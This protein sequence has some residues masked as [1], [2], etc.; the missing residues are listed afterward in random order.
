MRRFGLSGG[1]L[2]RQLRVAPQRVYEILSGRRG[3]TADTALRLSRL[4][5]TSPRYW[6]NLQLEF[7]LAEAE[8]LSGDA[9]ETEVQALLRG[10]G[11]FLEG[12]GDTFN[13]AG[14]DNQ[15]SLDCQNI[16]GIAVP[17]SLGELEARIYTL[18]HGKRRSTDGL[19][20]ELDIGISMLNATLVLLELDGHVQ[21]LPG[22]TYTAPG[23]G[24]PRR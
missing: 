24:V 15:Q 7:E 11:G 2:A 3:V 20:A 6:L 23:R 1:E 18:L 13:V 21:R 5:G 8:R 22:D 12:A 10:G 9:I 16:E 17:S 4:F 14:A 19:L